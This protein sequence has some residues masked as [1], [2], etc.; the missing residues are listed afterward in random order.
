M[1]FFNQ[2]SAGL[3]KTKQ[4]FV[5][6]VTGIISGVKPIS[7][8]LFEELEE[9]LIQADVG[10]NTSLKLVERLR[11][12]AREHKLSEAGEL[13]TFLEKGIEA[14]LTAGDH[15]L[16]L[17]RGRLNVILMVGVNGAG[18]TTS[19]GKL[20]TYLKGENY[21]VLAAAGDTFR[22]AAI[23]QL[24]VW[25]R[26]AGVDLI[27][28]NEGADPAA[29]VFDALAAAK[30]RKVDV[31]VIDTAGR[32]Q[33]KTNLMEELKK[34]RRVVDKEADGAQEILLALD[35]TTGQNAL[36]QAKLFTEAV[37]V[38]GVI[39]TKLDGTAKGGVILGIQDEYGLPVKFIGTGEKN[40]DFTA[41][42]PEVFSKALLYEN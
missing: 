30:S 1:G 23:D 5:E 18:K 12:S 31:L 32:L 33:N 6:K 38:T 41:F 2:L 29:V 34:I 37:G 15:A 13:K 8:E 36:S 25:C 22:A 3:G 35:A 11:K 40:T 42:D 21:K 20:L 9:A 10:V 14:I 17:E 27:K 7:E 26:R 28:H 39:L 19:I 4:A 24:E 16:H